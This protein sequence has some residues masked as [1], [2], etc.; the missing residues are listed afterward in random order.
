M[1]QPNTFDLIASIV[2]Q[3]TTHTYDFLRHCCRFV[4]ES[5]LGPRDS[6]GIVALGGQW[7][8]EV[9]DASSPEAL[10]DVH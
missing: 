9:V 6:G 5:Q 8:A 4:V 2:D 7:D 1:L 10:T 3:T